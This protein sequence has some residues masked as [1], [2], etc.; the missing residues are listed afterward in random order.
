[1]MMTKSCSRHDKLRENLKRFDRKTRRSS[2]KISSR[3]CQSLT[4]DRHVSVICSDV[5]TNSRRLQRRLWE[6]R[7]SRRAGK[8]ALFKSTSSP[9]SIFLFLLNFL[10]S[11]FFSYS[12]NSG[13][14]TYAYSTKRPLLRWN[15]RFR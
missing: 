9:T 8:I 7:S 3:S 15:D 6:S 5:R 12:T 11:S 14:R 4:D 13:T 10:S 2:T 1:M